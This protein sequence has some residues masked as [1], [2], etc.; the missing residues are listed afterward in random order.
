MI[1]SFLGLLAILM[2]TLAPVVSHSLAAMRSSGDE[3][4]MHCS[5]P[6]MQ[7]GH[8]QS[9]APMSGAGDACGYCSLF[10][11]MPAVIV[12]PVVFAQVVEAVLQPRATRF[13]SVRLEEPLKPGQPRAPPFLFS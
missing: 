8:A 3:S 11:H 5:M 6:S 1:G 12:P 4:G 13:E 9:H 10:A 7:D 2:V